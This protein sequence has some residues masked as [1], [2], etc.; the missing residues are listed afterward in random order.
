MGFSTPQ[1]RHVAPKN[2]K[3]GIA[4]HDFYEI[5]SISA[6]IGGFYVF[7]LVAFGEQTTKLLCATAELL[8]YRE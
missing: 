8:V 4:M 7:N 3:F 2:V 6:S 5:F 1:R